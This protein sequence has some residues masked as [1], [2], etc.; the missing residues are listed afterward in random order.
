V[1]EDTFRR[2][3]RG[4]YIRFLPLHATQLPISILLVVAEGCRFKLCEIA[5]IWVLIGA[6]ER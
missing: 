2:E 4:T 5:S 1:A 6:F 3:S